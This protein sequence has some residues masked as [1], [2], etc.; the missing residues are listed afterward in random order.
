M[1]SF[2]KPQP[3]FRVGLLVEHLNPPYPNLRYV[4]IDNRRFIRP[5]GETEKQ[6]VYD[7]MMVTIEGNKISSSTRVSSVP[8]VDL[9]FIPGIQ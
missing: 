8:E 5:N 9:D 6:W 7:G 2:F 1:F 3:K 4:L